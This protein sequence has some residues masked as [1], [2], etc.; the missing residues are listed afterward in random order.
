ME[1]FDVSTCMPIIYK[2]I[3]ELSR[4]EANVTF[5]SKMSQNI[6]GGEEWPFERFIN[7]TQ[8]CPKP[9]SAIEYKGETIKYEGWNLNPGKLGPG[10]ISGL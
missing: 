7:L 10:R 8:Q 4:I 2:T 3:Y 5:C 9:C 1:E 6:E